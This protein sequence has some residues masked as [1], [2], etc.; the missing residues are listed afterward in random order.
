MV[1]VVDDNY[2]VLHG[3]TCGALHLNV[4]QLAIETRGAIVF[5]CYVV[6]GIL[7]HTAITLVHLQ[8]AVRCKKDFWNVHR[9]L[10]PKMPKLEF[11]PGHIARRRTGKQQ[12]WGWSPNLPP[13]SSTRPEPRQTRLLASI[14][15]FYSLGYSAS[16]AVRDS[17][18]T[19]PDQ[20]Y[21]P[22]QNGLP[23]LE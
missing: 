3:R 1:G 22:S 16:G 15:S 18:S 10:F 20:V 13:S 6:P 23:Q 11:P 14:F 8:G 4:H 7:L 21:N 9:V 5:L 12:R 19:A 17:N 2:L